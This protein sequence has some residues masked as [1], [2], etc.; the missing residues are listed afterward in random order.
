MAIIFDKATGKP[1]A[2]TNDD[3]GKSLA[4]YSIAHGDRAMRKYDVCY[5]SKDGAGLGRM[6]TYVLP[7]YAVMN[8]M[9]FVLTRNGT[10]RRA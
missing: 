7:E 6:A 4:H 1:V 10:Y 2:Y 3:Y 9:T 8:G 5:P